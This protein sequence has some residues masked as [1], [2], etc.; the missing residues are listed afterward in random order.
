M[1]LCKAAIN[2]TDISNLFFIEVLGLIVSTIAAYFL[3][4][5]YLLYL[6]F[7][8]ADSLFCPYCH[9]SINSSLKNRNSINSQKLSDESHGPFKVHNAVQGE[10]RTRPNFRPNAAISA[11][12]GSEAGDAGSFRAVRYYHSQFAE[13]RDAILT[14]IAKNA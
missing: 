12:A 14:D 6:I 11:Y 4:Q 7:K 13:R 1:L 2:A 10:M 8:H 9:H 3:S 5:S